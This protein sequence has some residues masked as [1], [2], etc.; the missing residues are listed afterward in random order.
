MQFLIGNSDLGAKIQLL[1]VGE[2]G[3]GVNHHY[4][5]IGKCNKPFSHRLILGHYGFG[6]VGAEIGDVITCS[7][8]Q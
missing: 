5:A 3:S 6:V 7:I 1:S 8:N 2:A 4:C